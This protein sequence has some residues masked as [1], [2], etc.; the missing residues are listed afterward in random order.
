MGGYLDQN[1]SEFFSFFKFKPL[2]ANRG[3]YPKTHFRLFQA[4]GDSITKF[5]VGV[6]KKVTSHIVQA[7]QLLFKVTEVKVQ[8]FTVRWYIS[9]LFDL[10]SYN[11]V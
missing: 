5:F 7:F 6:S 4:N 3:L 8:N 11:L 9:L 10:E 2:R 1:R